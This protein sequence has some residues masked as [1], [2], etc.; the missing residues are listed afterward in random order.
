[1]SSNDGV[2]VRVSAE[3]ASLT[4][5]NI[6]GHL[7]REIV[8]ALNP[9]DNALDNILRGIRLALLEK[10]EVIMYGSAGKVVGYLALHIDWNKYAIYLET[11]GTNTFR[12]D[13]TQP[14]TRQLS[15]LLSKA[16]AYIAEV[17]Q[18]LGVQSVRVI[19]T[20][21]PG[22]EEDG[23]KILNTSPLSEDNTKDL[24]TA[25]DGHR[26]EVTD[27]AFGELTIEFRYRE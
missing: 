11:S 10:V 13:P 5:A 8:S 12:L 2:R 19:Y 21:R 6:L 18:R 22:K 3:L 24:R 27:S 14:V 23:I 17:R 16:T 15:P 20:W 4:R 25:K 26:M 9:G 1:M 7:A